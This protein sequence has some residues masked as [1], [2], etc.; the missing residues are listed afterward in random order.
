[1]A[2]GPRKK[3]N[4]AKP[5]GASSD[6]SKDSSPNQHQQVHPPTSAARGTS[7]TPDRSSPSSIPRLDGNRDTSPLDQ[8]Q[9]PNFSRVEG[10]G[11]R[12]FAKAR[13]VSPLCRSHSPHVLQSAMA[14]LMMISIIIIIL[15]LPSFTLHK[16]TFHHH[17]S[18]QPPSLHPT[19]GASPGRSR[20]AKPAATSVYPLPTRLQALNSET[21]GL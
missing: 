4:K 8:L 21:R 7:S 17:F 11:V 5:P 9:L 14:D 18:A 12:E 20:R 3:P 13:G 1:M 16:H 15:L 6:A 19:P 2:A 10:L